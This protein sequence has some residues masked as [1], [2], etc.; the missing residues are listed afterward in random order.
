MAEHADLHELIQ[1]AKALKHM[2]TGSGVEPIAELLDELVSTLAL[3]KENLDALSA[4][5]TPDEP[6]GGR[7]D[8]LP[9]AEAGLSVGTDEKQSDTTGKRKRSGS[10]KKEGA[11]A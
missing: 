1:K 2:Y 10:R 9:V 3:V 4:K 5:R 7:V 6:A 8:E 11:D